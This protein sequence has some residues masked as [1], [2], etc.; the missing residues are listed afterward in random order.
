METKRVL[1]VILI[2]RLLLISTNYMYSGNVIR[3]IFMSTISV[4]EKKI[5]M[6]LLLWHKLYSEAMLRMEKLRLSSFD[7]VCSCS[8]WVFEILCANDIIGIVFWEKVS[9]C[10]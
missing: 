5:Y 1:R 4:F 2:G 3:V 6:R 8:A 10:M 9:P 7:D